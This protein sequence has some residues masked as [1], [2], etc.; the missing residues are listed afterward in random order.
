[1]AGYY[2][3]S[4]SN[5]AVAAE[6][7]NCFPLS[8]ATKE[9]A[10]QAKDKGIK[11]TRWQARIVLETLGTSEYHHCSSYYNE[12]LYYN[13]DDALEA[14]QSG[15]ISIPTEKPKVEATIPESFLAEVTWLEWG[16]TRKRPVAYKKTD[17]AK[18]TKKG[19][20]Y[21]IESES[22]GTFIKREGTR[23]FEFS[24]LA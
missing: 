20:T 9:L 18:V 16:G 17:K 23:G 3:F 12:V 14:L 4:K 13:V 19:K 21:T 24:K 2:G 5:N 22:Y 11:L 7:N 8:V 10:A 6:S 15:E 1:M